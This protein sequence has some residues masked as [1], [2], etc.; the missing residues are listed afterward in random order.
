MDQDDPVCFFSRTSEM[1]VLTRKPPE[2]LF[3]GNHIGVTVT[4]AVG[5]KPRHIT[6]V[7]APHDVAETARQLAANETSFQRHQ[8]Q[9]R[10]FANAIHTTNLQDRTQHQTA[11]LDEKHGAKSPWSPHDLSPTA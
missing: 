8:P 4:E 9:E 10:R 11:I 3:L 2:T 1:L 5:G 6:I 7:K